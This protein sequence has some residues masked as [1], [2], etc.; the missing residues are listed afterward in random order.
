MKKIY[1]FV[2][3]IALFV[4]LSFPIFV[5]ANTDFGEDSAD[6]LQEDVYYSNYSPSTL[7]LSETGLENLKKT[8]LNGLD[9]SSSKIYVTTY[10]ITYEEFQTIYSN[11][12]NDN[13]KLFYV[14]SSYSYN[15]NKT[16]GYMNYVV[17][18]YVMTSSQI[19]SAKIIYE[20]GV[21]K[22]LSQINNTMSEIQ[23]ALVLH[24]YLANISTYTDLNATGDKPSYH[25]AYGIYLDGYTVCAGYTL[26]YSDLLHRVGIDSKYVI[27]DEMSHAWNVIKINNKWYN[28][29]LTFDELQ[30]VSGTNLKGTIAHNC[31]MKS[32]EGIKSLVGL[33]HHGIIYPDG[34]ECSDTSYDNYFWNNV[35]SNIYAFD[36]KYYYLDFNNSTK[37]LNLVSFDGNNV[38]ILNKS[39]YKS[40][41]VSLTSSTDVGTY[42]YILPFS[43]LVKNNNYL[44]FSYVDNGAKISCY[45]VNNNVEYKNILS[46]DSY[47][48]GLDITNGIISYSTYA[49][50][51]N[52]IEM[53]QMNIFDTIYP[54]NNTKNNFN[55]C[56]DLNTD[57]YV[58]SKDYVILS[59]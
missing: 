19:N 15:F 14:S 4:S 49:D 28:V 51:Y 43:K 31:F 29:D 24:D 44:Y 56:A 21:Q 59:N 41:S 12:I 5:Y 36:N 33:G 20:A 58:N 52:Y 26:S 1:A 38:N 11:V 53:P 7:S 2:I 42:S 18:E 23:K 40:Y 34:V 50:R 22:A 17:P 30:I 6:L 48:F 47:N 16:T 55:P 10:K 27:S 54:S 57:G 32:D 9:S 46:H 25:S 45:D 35:N 39:D 13:P 3:A 8:I 37:V